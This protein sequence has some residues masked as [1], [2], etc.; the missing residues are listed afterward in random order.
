LTKRIER[1]RQKSQQELN[2]LSAIEFACIADATAAAAKLSQQIVWHQLAEIEIVE[3]K[4]YDKPGKP[5]PDAIPSRIGFRVTAT[6]VAIDS[7]LTAP[8]VRCGRFILA[9]NVQGCCCSECL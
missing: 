4:H 2:Q 3:K 1:H 8:R 6:V 7:E 9:T 5:K